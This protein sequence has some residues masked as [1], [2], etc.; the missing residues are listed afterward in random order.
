MPAKVK[1]SIRDIDNNIK[2]NYYLTN[3]N[4]ANSYFG[5]VGDSGGNL[6]KLLI[7]IESNLQFDLIAF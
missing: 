5:F 1:H 4:C 3:F 6:L 2:L 7:N